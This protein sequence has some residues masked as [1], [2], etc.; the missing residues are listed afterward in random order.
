M[1]F[2]FREL[3]FLSLKKSI[4]KLEVNGEN[5]KNAL[6]SFL[7]I[8]LTDALHKLHFPS[9]KIIALFFKFFIF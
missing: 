3:I 6:E 2:E 7:I 9:K 1:V 4:E 5:I 8:K